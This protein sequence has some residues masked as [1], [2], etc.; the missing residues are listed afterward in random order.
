MAGDTRNPLD[1]LEDLDDD[2]RPI[3]RSVKKK[4]APNWELVLPGGKIFEIKNKETAVIILVMRALMKDFNNRKIILRRERYGQMQD[5][6]WKQ[7]AYKPKD[8]SILGDQVDLLL[9]MIKKKLREGE[10][11]KNNG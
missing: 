4:F 10:E 2:Y 9:E 3:S 5:C 6:D 1:V 7:L 8:K 11:G